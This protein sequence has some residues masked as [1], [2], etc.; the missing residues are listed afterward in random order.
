[1]VGRVGDEPPAVEAGADLGAAGDHPLAV[2]DQQG[3]GLV[4]E[5]DAPA[6]MGLGAP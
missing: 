1:V 4:V 2:F 3:H 5:G 6:L